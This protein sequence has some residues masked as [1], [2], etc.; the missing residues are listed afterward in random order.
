MSPPFSD[1]QNLYDTIDGTPIG[2]V[3]WQSTTLS[4]DGPRPEQPLLWMES[5]YTIWFHDPQSL[6]KNMLANSDI[7]GSFNYTPYQQYD[8]KGKRRYEHFMSGNWAWKHTV[9][10]IFS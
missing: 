1:H 7:A 5:E 8:N 6:F 2:G 10:K 9:C 4:Y 3:P